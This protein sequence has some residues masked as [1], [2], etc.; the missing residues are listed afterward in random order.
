MVIAP[1]GQQLQKRHPLP[2]FQAMK[3]LPGSIGNHSSDC[4]DNALGELLLYRLAGIPAALDMTPAWGNSDGN[5]AWAHPID[6]RFHSRYEVDAFNRDIPKVY[7]QTY[8]RQHADITPAHDEFVPPFFRDVFLKDVT[9]EYVNTADVTE[10]HFPESVRYGYLCVFNEQEWKPVAQAENHQGTCTFACLGT[11]CLYLPVYYENAIPIPVANPF[12][13]TANGNK[14]RITAD[15]TTADITLQRKYPLEKRKENHIRP[16]NCLVEGS[17]SPDFRHCDTLGCVAEHNP[18]YAFRVQAEG[19]YR[20]IRFS[21][22]RNTIS[23]IAEIYFKGKHHTSVT[24]KADR[25]NIHI[26]PAQR[27]TDNNILTPLILSEQITYAFPKD[28]LPTSIDILP[29]TDGNGIYPGDTYELFYFDLKEGGWVTCGAQ[30]ADDYQLTFRHVPEKA[31]FWLQNLT[32][33]KQE[34]VFTYEHK[35]QRFW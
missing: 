15:G 20:F 25:T 32:T 8:S 5:H 22:F 34:R 4:R 3:K 28:S 10:K 19:R 17:N 11:N 21:P 18:T 2:Y 12:I 23:H 30:K 13:L 24:G 1:L 35:A 31:L 7:R 9:H 6:A 14:Q 26:F 16:F 33:G 27:L 29:A